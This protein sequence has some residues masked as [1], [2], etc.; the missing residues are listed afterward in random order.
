MVDSEESEHG[1]IG[2]T[3][4]GEEAEST[5]VVDDC[6]TQSVIHDVLHFQTLIQFVTWLVYP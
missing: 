1:S 2:G 4:H 5:H 3:G 6:V